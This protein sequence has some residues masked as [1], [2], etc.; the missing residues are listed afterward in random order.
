MARR[1]HWFESGTGTLAVLL[2]SAS[3]ID[4]LV[5]T[6]VALQIEWNKLHAL[7]QTSGLNGPP[8]DSVQA[9]EALGGAP[10]DWLTLQL[11]VYGS[12]VALA[13]ALV[14]GLAG[15][16]RHAWI[17]VLNRV[18]VEFFRGTATLV[19]LFWF[20]YALPLVGIR[21]NST[22]VAAVLALGLNIGAYG[23]EVV[24]GSIKAV[25]KAQFE[26]TVALNFTP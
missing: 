3:D 9:A 11:T 4:D 10:G 8:E 16:S 12:G 18:Y 7:L 22:M 20:F 21:L 19:L 17:R 1:R 23:A 2:A 15:T 13:L 26:A 25:P 5:P 14:F 24:R 6:L